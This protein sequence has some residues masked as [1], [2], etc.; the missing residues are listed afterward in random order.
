MT[1]EDR[2]TL[3][4]GL[5]QQALECIRQA[6]DAV[7]A[8]HWLGIVASR[9]MP[10]LPLTAREQRKTI[11]ALASKLVETELDT[12]MENASRSWESYKRERDAS[13]T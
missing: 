11:L 9:P 6:G 1:P 13:K 12:L 2:S 4:G 5:R 10:Q 7:E 3:V 8:A